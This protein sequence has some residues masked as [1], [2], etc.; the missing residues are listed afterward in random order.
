ML[1]TEL[2]ELYKLTDVMSA[3]T[4]EFSTDIQGKC[5]VT[6]LQCAK[7]FHTSSAEDRKN[8]CTW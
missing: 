7:M 8:I 1:P 4:T 2:E 3:R 5:S 6:V